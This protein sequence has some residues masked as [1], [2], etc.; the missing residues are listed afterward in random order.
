MKQII[1]NLKTGQ[2]LLEEVPAPQVKEGAVL[3]RTTHSLVSL[4]T[5]RMLVEFGKAGSIEKPDLLSLI[6][7]NQLHLQR[8]T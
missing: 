6:L 4:G 3:I 5:E 2:T 8:N 7:Q 1:Q